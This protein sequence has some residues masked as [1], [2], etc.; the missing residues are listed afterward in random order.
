MRKA[1]RIN[2]KYILLKVKEN[3]VESNSERDQHKYLK[4]VLHFHYNEVFLDIFLPPDRLRDRKKEHDET[5]ADA[6][7]EASKEN[8]G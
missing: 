8:F 2:V 3:N 4:S 1:G 7:L 5:V 6:R